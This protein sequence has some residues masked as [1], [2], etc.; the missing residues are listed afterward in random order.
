MNAIKQ[1][2]EQGGIISGPFKRQKGMRI[3]EKDRL[4]EENDSRFAESEDGTELAHRIT[5]SEV[6]KITAYLRNW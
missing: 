5:H 1:L 3:D 4:S 2:L 6:E